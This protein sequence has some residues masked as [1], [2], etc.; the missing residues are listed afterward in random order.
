MP[1]ALREIGHI[2]E[3]I[4]D[5][6]PEAARRLVSRLMEAG[7]SLLLFSGRGR[8]ADDGTRELTIAWRYIIRY[9][10]VDN[11]VAI[12]RVRHGMRR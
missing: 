1:A 4:A 11:T 9:E 12:L 3:Y 8:L 10:I 7:D 5:T 6:N 2:R